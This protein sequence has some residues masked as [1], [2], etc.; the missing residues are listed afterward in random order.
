MI[1]A[2]PN[3]HKMAA[4]FAAFFC[5]DKTFDIA[6][7]HLFLATHEMLTHAKLLGFTLP[8]ATIVIVAIIFV[9]HRSAK[10]DQQ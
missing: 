2:I 6:R 7:E 4:S 9:L 8:V 3:R 10:G 1:P 5:A